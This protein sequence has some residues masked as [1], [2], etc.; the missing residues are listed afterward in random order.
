M[1][2]VIALFGKYCISMTVNSKFLLAITALMAVC[3][4]AFGRGKAD[5]A[6]PVLIAISASPSFR[7][8]RATVLLAVCSLGGLLF[9]QIAHSQAGS[10]LAFVSAVAC[11]FVAVMNRATAKGNEAKS[12]GS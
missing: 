5:W 7:A 10:V 9:S 4:I 8:G 1:E 6:L 2:R 12:Q 3:N 11:V